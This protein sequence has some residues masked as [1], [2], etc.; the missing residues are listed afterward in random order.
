MSRT[1]FCAVAMDPGRP[2]IAG[3]VPELSDIRRALP[4]VNPELVGHDI[5]FPAMLRFLPQ[6]GS[7]SWWGD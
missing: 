2:G 1:M 5:A 6:A 4:G 7:V 3:R